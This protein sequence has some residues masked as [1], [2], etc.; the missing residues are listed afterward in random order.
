[1]SVRARHWLRLFVVSAAAVC[2]SVA[3]AANKGNLDGFDDFMAKAMQEFQAPGAAVA[4]VQDGK[5]VFVKGYGYRD[6]ANRRPV[7][8]ATLFPIASITK[9]FTV[10]SLGTLADRGKLDWDK[11]VR[12]YLPGFR[13][14]DPVATEQLTTRDMVTHR[15]GLPRHD[16]V[17]Y[18]SSFSREQ[19]VEK[20]RYLEP[21]KPLR[22]KFQYNNLMFVTAG[23]LGG[24]I[25]GTSWEELVRER[26]LQPL[27][28]MHTKFSSEEARQTP[29]YAL[30]YRKNRK[31]EVVSEIEFSRWGDV[32]P[33]GAINSSIDDMAKYLLM[34]LNKGTVA[35]KQVLGKNNAEQMQSPQMVLQ[36]S[37]LFPELG[38]ASYGMGLFIATYRGHK[39][40]Y[41]GG[42]LDGFSLQLSFLPNDGIGVVVLTN[43]SGTPLRDL[44]PFY[45]YDR[46]LGLESIDWV[47]RYRQIERKGRDQELAADKK[48]YTGRKPGT[49]PSHELSEYE[50]EFEHPGYGKLAIRVDSAVGSPRLLLKLNDVERPL[51]HF[52]Y[53]TFRV[54]ENPL[55]P[56]EKL[57]VTFPTNAQGE[58]ATAQAILEEN[59][60]EIVFTRAPEKRMFEPSFLRQFT[61]GYDAPGQP[62]TVAL[63]GENTLQLILPGAPPRKL[64]PRHGTRFDVEGLTGVTLEFKADA[65]GQAQEVVVYTPDSV[66]V[67]PRKK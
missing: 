21:N 34:H 35:G 20:L 58:I 60:K 18:S 37:P 14:Y 24:R 38:E 13:M 63:A 54:P 25:N 44:V 67:V 28:M 33:A 12:E 16:L 47:E 40:V 46:L 22:S 2:L 29:D 17:W 6:A 42:N 36:G 27:G 53:D 59:V 8:G 30:P 52:H 50:G 43:L 9:S 5:I 3:S 62:W 26:V 4:V 15:S 64:I 32:G 49:R 56:F 55:D 7:T 10:T 31:T 48:G 1:M 51:E 19:L 61:G 57:R 39:H 65:S 23:Y 45:V 66:S 41:H 11:P